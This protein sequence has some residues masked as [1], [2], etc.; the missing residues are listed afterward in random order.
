MFEQ[1]N[2][3]EV[4]ET[5]KVLGVEGSRN[6]VETKREETIGRN[7]IP[8]KSTKTGR[9]PGTTLRHDPTRGY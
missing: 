7:T 9:I 6:P 2:L 4:G 3:Q 8:D 1:E 5:T